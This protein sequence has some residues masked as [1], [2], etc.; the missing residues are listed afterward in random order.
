MVSDFQ[1]DQKMGTLMNV[2]LVITVVVTAPA[3]DHVVN[4]KSGFYKK[5]ELIIDVFMCIGTFLK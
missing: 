2:C 5:P 4:P 3:A 1:T